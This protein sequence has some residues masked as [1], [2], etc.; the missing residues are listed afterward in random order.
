MTSRLGRVLLLSLGLA[1]GATPA[2]VHEPGGHGGPAPGTGFNEQDALRVS[3]AAVGR[4]LEDLTLRDR[5]GQ[6]VSLAGYRGQ[7]LVISLIYTSCYH[8]CPTTTRHLA[9]VVQTARQALGEKSFRVLTIGFD[10]PRD[11]SE[12][13]RVFARQQGVDEAGWE[14]LSA[15]AATMERLAKN[16]GFIYFSSPHGFDHLI[17]ATVV[18]ARGRIYRQVYGMTFE[19]PQLVEPLKELVF[20]VQPGEAVLSSVWKKVKLFCTTYDASRDGYRFDYSLFVG[21]AIGLLIIGTVSFMLARAAWRHRTGR[22][23]ASRN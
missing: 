5:A 14:F 13:M 21:I 6:P 12:A 2:A 11:T 7:P 3:Q 10:T 17:Q 16:L 9:R 20:G 1:A 4:E 19:T 8:I 23:A 18:D 22:T 15:D